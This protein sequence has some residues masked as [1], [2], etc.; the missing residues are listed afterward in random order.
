VL[1]SY[2]QSHRAAA[3]D[4]LPPAGETTPD[5]YPGYRNRD[6]DG[7]V[8][9]PALARDWAAKPPREVWRKPCGAGFSG[10]AVAAGRALT[11]EQRG[12]DE[13]VV[14]Y[15]AATGNE[16]WS[17]SYP[18]RFYDARGGE[19]PMATPTLDR[20]LVYSL[21]GTGRL[22]CLDLA[23]GELKWGKD[24]LGPGENLTWGMAGS[25]LVYDDVVVVNPGGQNGRGE[26]RAVMAFDRKTGASVWGAGSTQAGYAAPA[27]ATLDGMR[28]VV[29]FDGQE[30][31]GYDAKGKAGKKGK[32]WSLPWQTQMGI[33]VA[34]PLVLSEGR[35][36]VTSGYGVGC[37]AVAVSRESKPEVHNWH[38]EQTAHAITMQGK[39]ASPVEYKGLVY[40]L[41]EG[42]LTCVNPTSL[43]RVWKGPRY[44]HGQLLRCD[45]LLL[46]LSE[47]GDLALVSA[48]AESSREL[49]RV[50]ALA[51]DK[52]WNPPC[53]AGGKAYVRNHVEMACYD[54]HE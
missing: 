26:G 47:S 32:L 23:T 18:A 41:S 1:E 10:F 7:V 33:N 20:G 8:R 11:A 28:Q 40:G 16:L 48:A 5:D 6:R 35:L 54:L 43:K 45:D 37:G 29:I 50:K 19:G 52:T 31:A 38:A 34:Q 9:G 22:V 27:L 14:C 15:D 12:G 24:L 36:F 25:P 49:G 53:L 3:P 2:R 51:G 30:V 17:H 21:G 42:T 4:A 46:V 44:G 13:A 39:F